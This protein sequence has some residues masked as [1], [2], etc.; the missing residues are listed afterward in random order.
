MQKDF[1]SLMAKGA[2][3]QSAS[4]GSTRTGEA[5]AVQRGQVTTGA[6]PEP[7]L[8]LQRVTAVLPGKAGLVEQA[9]ASRPIP[10]PYWSP[11][12]PVA[13]MTTL[14]GAV[15]S[16][17]HNL[18]CLGVELNAA[19]AA[20]AKKDLENDDSRM[21]PGRKTLLVIGNEVRQVDKGVLIISGGVSVEI[22]PGGKVTVTA[23]D[24]EVTGNLKVGGDVN[25]VGN[26]A[27]GGS[28]AMVGNLSAQGNAAIA[29]SGFVAGKELMVVGGRDSGGDTMTDSGQ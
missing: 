19:N 9:P 20:P 16:D 10:C 13:G 26:V 3:A 12:Q 11:P 8:G 29:G 21:I 1:S 24:V 22:D 14:L 27:V 25:V 5:A 17:P 15:D 18:A 6:D 28:V 2:I 7:D 4:S 23:A